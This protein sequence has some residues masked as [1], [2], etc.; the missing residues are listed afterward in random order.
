MTSLVRINPQRKSIS[1][2]NGLGH[3]YTYNKAECKCSICGITRTQLIDPS[4]KEA[5][6]IARTQMVVCMEEDHVACLTMHDN[7]AHSVA[8][9]RTT[10]A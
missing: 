6:S 4:H 8:L 7:R 3:G 5:L 1:V 9:S 10:C 2:C